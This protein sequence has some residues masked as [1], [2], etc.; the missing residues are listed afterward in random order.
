MHAASIHPRT[1]KIKKIQDRY[2]TNRWMIFGN[3]LKLTT[4]ASFIFTMYNLWQIF[5]SVYLQDNWIKVK[6]KVKRKIKSKYIINES[7][8]IVSLKIIDSHYHFYLNLYFD[9]NFNQDQINKC[10]KKPLLLDLSELTINVQARLS[11]IFI[12]R[13]SVRIN[14]N[15]LLFFFILI[16]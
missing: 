15:M 11:I 13:L 4:K 8:I 16:L 2:V 5:N 14:N 1:P 3:Q 12:K 9:T 10:F 7:V 6:G